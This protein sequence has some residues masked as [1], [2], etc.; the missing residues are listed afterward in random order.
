M[1]TTSTPLSGDSTPTLLPVGAET[2]SA[3][4]SDANCP[5]Q[6]VPLA[7]QRVIVL[8]GSSG[9]G[10][11]TARAL[12][13]AGVRVVIG[14]R[15][16]S[17]LTAAQARLATV[18]VSV[19]AEV[20]DATDRDA[21][22]AFYRRVGAFDH[23]V[24]TLSGAAGAGPFRALNLNDVRRGFDAKFWAQVSAAQSAL[25]TL[26]VDGSITFVTAISARMANPGTAGLAAINGALEAMIR[27]LAAELRPLR[28]NAVSPGVIDTPWWDVLPAEEKTAAF[29]RYA[30]AAAV[31]R[32]GCPEDVAAS[33]LLLVTNGFV[34]GT[35]L[36][37][38]GG[39][40]LG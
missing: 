30:A 23:L 10:L 38:D 28:V 18:S 16:V 7:G 21:L 32:V 37:I 11:A 20:V 14:G 12:L 36:E 39:L 35:V 15:D 22:T 26:R 2:P 1:S 29:A 13:D 8:G 25:D 40:R 4:P 34:T 33:I 27:P 24:L 9:V 3:A 17:R 5:Q 31:G 6:S 19:T